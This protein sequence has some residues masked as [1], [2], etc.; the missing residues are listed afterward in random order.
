[1]R[2]WDPTPHAVHEPVLMPILYVVKSFRHRVTKTAEGLQ[3]ELLLTLEEFC[4][5]E[6]TFD[7]LQEGGR[8]FTAI[9]PKAMPRSPLCMHGRVRLGFKPIMQCCAALVPV[10]DSLSFTSLCLHDGGSLLCD[11]AA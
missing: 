6:G 4:S 7:G 11:Q 1:M 8:H 5:E 2:W 3:V 9:F 10:C